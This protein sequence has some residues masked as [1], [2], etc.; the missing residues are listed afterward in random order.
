[1][2]RSKYPR[3]SVTVK[4]LMDAVTSVGYRAAGFSQST[5]NQPST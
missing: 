3:G 1:M 4:Q 2:R 5:A